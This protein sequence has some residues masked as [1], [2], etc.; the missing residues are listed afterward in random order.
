MIPP[1]DP[2][3]GNLPPGI[4]E[5]KWDEFA[6]RYGYTPHRLRLIAGLKDALDNLRAASCRQVYVDGSFVS[7]KEFPEDFDVC[8]EGS[9]VNHRRLDPV[10]FDFS[11]RRAAQKAKF[12]GEFFLAESAAEPRGTRFL[13]FFQQDK[14]THA[15]KGIIVIDLGE[16]P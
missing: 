1:F 13:E 16:L 12:G 5:A 4:H 2:D 11:N 9:G 8:W 14:H 6:A 7:G 15:P 10:F 3:T